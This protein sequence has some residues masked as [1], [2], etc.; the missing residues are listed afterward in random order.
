MKKVQ[1]RRARS[2]HPGV[3][4][5]KRR[6]AAGLDLRARWFDPDTGKP[7]EFSFEPEGITTAEGR[8]K[9]MITKSLALGERERKLATGAATHTGASLAD[10]IEGYFSTKGARLKGST[11]K[12][13]RTATTIFLEW[14][15]INRIRLADD[16]RPHHLA[17]F[18][19][20]LAARPA[21]RPVKGGRRTERAPSDRTCSPGGVNN[22]LRSV[23]AILN[24]LRRVGRLPHITSDDI[25]DRIKP[26]KTAKP[27]PA[28]LRVAQI[29]TLLQAALSHDTGTFVMTRT[30][31]AAGAKGGT[32]KYDPI[33]PFIVFMLLTGCRRDEALMLRW[34]SVDFD[35]RDGRGR[36]AGEIVLRAGDVKTGHER[37][38]DLSI[39][40]GL[41]K[42]LE[43]LERGKDDVYVFGGKEPWSRSKVES[44]RKR[45]VD[46]LGAPDFCWSQT[47]DETPALRATCGT[48]L[49]NAPGIYAAAAAFHSAK[50]LGHSIVIAERHYV[51]LLKGISKSA[52]T[53]E[54]AMGITAD[55]AAIVARLKRRGSSSSVAVVSI[56]SATT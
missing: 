47:E 18:V 32:P 23:K 2:A 39:C 53:L 43:A 26:L 36:K 16:L 30:E 6:S 33:A 45:L 13:Y 25:K 24:Q 8:R 22:R 56:D 10:A 3:F 54:A 40:P 31:K 55:V 41:K 48:F 1:R 46:E 11:P 28:F 14:A 44:A 27:R 17:A 19:E 4:E 15:N 20:W 21:K 38:I 52:K 5:V 51:G 35:A 50:R 42:I 12:T 37:A 49:T 9:W 7:R 34:A 29:K